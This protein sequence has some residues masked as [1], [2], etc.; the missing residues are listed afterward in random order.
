VVSTIIL[1]FVRFII[2]AVLHKLG[3]LRLVDED[4]DLLGYAPDIRPLQPD[5]DFS[6]SDII[7]EFN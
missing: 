7:G 6:R 5:R 1:F 3:K 4:D 2:M